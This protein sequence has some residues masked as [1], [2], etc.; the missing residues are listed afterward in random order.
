MASNSRLRVLH[1]IPP[2]QYG[3]G[4][5]V[6]KDLVLH[7]NNYHDAEILLLCRS[8]KFENILDAHK[9]R[10][11]V[12]ENSE[13]ASSSGVTSF[14]L[15]LLKLV[16]TKGIYVYDFG[17]FD[18]VHC[19]GF[20]SVVVG[21]FCKFKKSTI[22]LVYTHHQQ[23]FNGNFIVIRILLAVYNK[24]DFVTFVSKSIQ[25]N[26]KTKFDLRVENC[27]IFN[28]IDNKFFRASHSF[29]QSSLAHN[30]LSLVYMSRFSKQK[31]HYKLIEAFSNFKYLN[32]NLRLEI[33]FYG[34]GAEKKKCEM[35]VREL[36]LSDIFYFDGFVN[37]NDMIESLTDMDMAVFPSEYE[38]FGVAA[39]ECVSFGLPVI[40]N[41]ENTTLAEV[42]GNA[43]WSLP[44][45]DMPKFISGCD[46]FDIGEKI[47][48]CI[49]RREFFKV[50]K[51]V[52]SYNKIYESLI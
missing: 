42:V 8:N 51:I 44:I 40:Y 46:S 22:R 5:S 48:N 1:I 16:I 19:H 28:P 47:D 18:V 34:E 27:V 31:S 52:A 35:L 26:F 12:L 10:Y 9:I 13:L 43:G 25:E 29:R 4:E 30:K 24:F 49:I 23:V 2:V 3:G 50:D 32:P 14:L 17:R 41:S 7:S 39:A 38:G 6:V 33:H 15:L 36:G 45:D 21:L 37:Q 20:P 11:S